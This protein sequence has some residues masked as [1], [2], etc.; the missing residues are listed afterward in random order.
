MEPT[1][2]TRAEHADI[3]QLNSLVNGAYRGENAKKGWTHE[4]DLIEGEL[5][6][7]E[8]VLRNMLANPDA[9]ILKYTQ[10]HKIIG[11][12][13]LEKRESHLYLGML[14]VS[15]D[16][17]ARGIGKKLLHAAELY[18]EKTNCDLIEMTVITARTEL[19]AWY[20]RNGYHQTGKTKPFH[21]ES[22]FGVPVQPVEFVVMEKRVHAEARSGEACKEEKE[23]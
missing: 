3:P 22:R 8:N 11:C 7:D 17:Q 15:P 5:R 23:R 19:L 12:V 21:T 14:T 20:E 16:V 9:V 1:A 18:A 4:A 2:I 10:D 13:Y 6:T